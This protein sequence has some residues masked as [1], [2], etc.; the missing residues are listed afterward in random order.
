MPNMRGDPGKNYA[1]LS[2]RRYTADPSY[3]GRI[4]NV[5]PGDVRDLINA[6]CVGGRPGS[7]SPTGSFVGVTGPQGPTGPTGIGV[8]GPAGPTAT[9]GVTGPQGP[10]SAPMGPTG[11]TGPNP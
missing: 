5:N 7:G 6:G 4:A 10:Q 2:G 8:T 3:G 11:P 9:T 1:P